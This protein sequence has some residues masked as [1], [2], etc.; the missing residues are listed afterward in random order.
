MK[1]PPPVSS[2]NSVKVDKIVFQGTGLAMIHS[3]GAIM[4][5]ILFLQP[6]QVVF[7]QALNRFMYRSGVSRCQMKIKL[8]MPIIFTSQY[9]KWSNTLFVASGDENLVCRSI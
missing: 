7:L 3:F 1:K 2:Q 9:S 4:E 5:I 8:P 6:L